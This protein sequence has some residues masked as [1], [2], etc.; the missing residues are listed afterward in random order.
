MTIA[1]PPSLHLN[2]L[3]SPFPPIPIPPPVH[4]TH[5]QLRVRTRTCLSFIKIVSLLHVFS[6]MNSRARICSFWWC[7]QA[8]CV[9]LE[10]SVSK[11]ALLI[12]PS[13]QHTHNMRYACP[14][15]KTLLA[16]VTQPR[17]GDTCTSRRCGSV[18]WVLM[19]GKRQL[20]YALRRLPL[21]VETCQN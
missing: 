15:T 7:L 21:V 2:P 19:R 1:S 9:G 6:D 18:G 20:L 10:I 4:L 5:Q 17:V 14:C 8:T 16:S 13:T 11:L 12:I 3:I